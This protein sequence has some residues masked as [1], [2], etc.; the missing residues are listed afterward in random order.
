[1]AET[2]VVPPLKI[3]PGNIPKKVPIIFFGIFVMKSC[4]IMSVSFTMLVCLYV[5][6]YKNS[7]SC[8]DFHRI[9]LMGSL[10]KFINVPVFVQ[11]EQ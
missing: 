3:M 7:N 1:L 6:A 9:F 10:L 2:S 8:T 5:S 11:V 4:N